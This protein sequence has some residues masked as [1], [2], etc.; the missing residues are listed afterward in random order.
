MI[1]KGL[2]IFAISF[3]VLLLLFISFIYL[4]YSNFEK[5]GYADIVNENHNDTIPFYYSNSGH[6]LIDVSLEDDTATYPFILDSG[7]SNIIFNKEDS[8]IELENNGFSFGIGASGNFF[9]SGIKKLNKL[10]LGNLSFENIHLKS[11]DYNADCF[12]AYGLIGTGIMR[13]LVW[14]IDFE[15][16]I[17]IVSDEIKRDF[18][19]QDVLKFKLSENSFGH[20]LRL[21]LKLSDRGQK[22]STLVDLGSNSNLS[23]DEDYILA[24][25]LSFDSKRFYGS[26]ASGLGDAVDEK[27]E[28][29]LYLIDTLS[30]VGSG[31]SINNFPISAEY[32]SLN[33]L[34]L[35]FLKNYKTTISWK[36][37]LLL[38]EPYDSVQNFIG[39]TAGMGTR[40]VKQDK[41]IQISSL[42]EGT[43]ASKLNL[44][45]GDEILA[46]NGLSVFN[47]DEYCDMLH[48]ISGID[49]ILVEV[50][51]HDTISNV[52]IIKEPIF[53]K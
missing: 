32:N 43:P 17:I 14:K 36:D 26:G 35:G 41:R 25:S 28:G 3:A 15:N 39:K 13:H 46:V 48:T 33:L 47:E 29:R 50:K 22:I 8:D 9:W 11:V 18:K 30:F 16:K 12:E 44:S 21:P 27:F 7:A 19:N 51:R 53:R 40:F 31:H 24:D 23:I 45:L 52:Q 37:D 42:T 2:K 1:K 10:Q 20:Q 49:T 38:L 5:L 34:G 4:M 6:I